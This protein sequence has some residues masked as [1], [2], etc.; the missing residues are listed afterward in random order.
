MYHL[1]TQ[2]CVWG[3]G[4]EG[5]LECQQRVVD[6]LQSLRAQT[7]SAISNNQVSQLV[8]RQL[9]LQLSV[10]CVFWLLSLQQSLPAW[11]Q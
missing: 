3:G 1:M 10:L 7:L 6:T 11:M 5:V 9:H 4:A 8:C 2:V